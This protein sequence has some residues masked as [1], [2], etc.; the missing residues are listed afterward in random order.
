MKNTLRGEFE[1]LNLGTDQPVLNIFSDSR[2]K[3]HLSKRLR[4]L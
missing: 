4:V 3:K 2:N 1:R